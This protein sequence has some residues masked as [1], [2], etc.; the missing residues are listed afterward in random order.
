MA[1][2][3]REMAP[4]EPG[5]NRKASRRSYLRFWGDCQLTDPGDSA[6]TDTASP[7]ADPT[8]GA[9]SRCTKRSTP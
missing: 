8:I 7:K 1:Y 3:W 4:G 5:A 6:I 9:D 2:P